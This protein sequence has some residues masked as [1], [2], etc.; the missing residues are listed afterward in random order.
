M[1]SFNKRV[2]TYLTENYKKKLEQICQD[3]E[4]KEAYILREIIKEYIE[5]KDIFKKK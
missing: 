2:V 5:R 1:N 3:R 4:E